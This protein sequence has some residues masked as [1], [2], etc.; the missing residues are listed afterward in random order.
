MA[1]MI[2][3]YQ[4]DTEVTLQGM[5]LI[6]GRDYTRAVCG[7][8]LGLVNVCCCHWLL[9]VNNVQCSAFDDVRNIHHKNVGILSLQPS[10]REVGL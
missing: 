7:V 10:I 1:I 9:N 2:L 6:R 8:D 3:C 5:I 4:V